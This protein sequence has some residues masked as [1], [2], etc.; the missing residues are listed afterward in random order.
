MLWEI[1]SCA[2]ISLGY[3]FGYAFDVRRKVVS[4][5]SGD[6]GSGVVES[7]GKF[8]LLMWIGSHGVL[9]YRGAVVD[10][11]LVSPV[12]CQVLNGTSRSTRL[13]SEICGSKVQCVLLERIGNGQGNSR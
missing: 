13:V 1:I 6:F 12:L 8:K 10:S 4:K 5:P 9:L 11:V 3:K 7:K 2:Y